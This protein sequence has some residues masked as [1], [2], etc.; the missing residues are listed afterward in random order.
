MALEIGARGS[1]LEHF[2]IV[3]RLS[4][5]QVQKL[6]P[7]VPPVP[8]Q[9]SVERA[10]DNRLD[11]GHAN[12]MLDLFRSADHEIA[13]VMIG[14]GVRPTGYIDLFV[15][16][17]ARNSMVLDASGFPRSVRGQERAQIVQIQ[18][19]TYITIEIAISRITRISFLRAPDLFTR[20]TVASKSGRTGSRKAR[21]ED[22]VTRTRIAKHQP[23][24]VERKPTQ[25]RLLQ[26]ILETG[27]IG[28]FRE[29]DASGLPAEVF[30]VVVA[31]DPNLSAHGLGM[32]FHQRAGTRGSPHR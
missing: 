22:G 30:A 25:I 2:L 18:I 31:S 15:R 16:S 1:Q 8:K 14:S 11:I 17:A 21:R 23:M 27:E 9:F 7:F 4:N 6:R 28:T 13:C 5:K 20:F 12:Q 26:I 32:L 24:R 19:V 10:Q 3:N 29:P